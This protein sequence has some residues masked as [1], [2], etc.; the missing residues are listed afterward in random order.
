MRPEVIAYEREYCYP[1]IRLHPIL[2]VPGLALL[3][4]AMQQCWQ[5]NA[6]QGSSQPNCHVASLIQALQSGSGSDMSSAAFP[7]LASRSS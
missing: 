2:L 7:A 5:H 1:Y 3:V 4:A 6:W